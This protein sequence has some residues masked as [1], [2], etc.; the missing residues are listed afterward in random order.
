MDVDYKRQG[1]VTT[2]ALC[3]AEDVALLE[4]VRPSVDWRA[5]RTV[6][7]GRG[8]SLAALDPI[9]PADDRAFLAEVAWIAR[10]AGPRW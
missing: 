4:V 8:S 7:A 5:V 6:V 2:V 9:A 10:V 1:G 3:A